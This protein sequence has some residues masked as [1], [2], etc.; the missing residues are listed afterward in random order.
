VNGA[1]E[2]DSDGDES[3]A[4][5]SDDEDTNSKVES[6]EQDDLADAMEL[7]EAASRNAPMIL[8][9]EEPTYLKAESNATTGYMWMIDADDCDGKLDTQ[10]QMLQAQFVT[11][12]EGNMMVG[13]PSSTLFTITAYELGIN[14]SVR[15]AYARPWEFSWDNPN[16][17]TLSYSVDFAN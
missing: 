11:D 16:S 13:T 6:A 9:L 14:C 7:S 1:G 10:D 8:E 15:F 12:E 2:G 3:G 17:Y 5:S 4:D